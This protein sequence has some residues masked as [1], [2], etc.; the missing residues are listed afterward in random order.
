MTKGFSLAVL[1]LMLASPAAGQVVQDSVRLQPV[2]AA[3]ND[4]VHWTPHEGPTLQP[5]E[6]VRLGI[7]QRDDEERA[8]SFNYDFTAMYPEDQSQE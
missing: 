2:T 4:I 3:G 8:Y 7:V 6:T 5:G 1:S